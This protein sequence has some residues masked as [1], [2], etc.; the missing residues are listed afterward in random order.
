MTTYGEPERPADEAA[1]VKADVFLAD[2]EK[3][4]IP[5]RLTASGEPL[6]VNG[7]W[8]STAPYKDMQTSFQSDIR[9]KLT[10]MDRS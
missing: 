1:V 2:L 3:G 8:Y 10:A 9:T 4:D 6:F 7:H 5:C